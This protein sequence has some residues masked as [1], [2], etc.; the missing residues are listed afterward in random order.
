MENMHPYKI[1]SFIIVLVPIYII[2]INIVHVFGHMKMKIFWLYCS[3]AVCVFL[4]FQYYLFFRIIWLPPFDFVS[5]NPIIDLL[6]SFE[7]VLLL[8]C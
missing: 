8:Y 2:L 4:V 5:I 7:K 3:I 6:L 1:Q